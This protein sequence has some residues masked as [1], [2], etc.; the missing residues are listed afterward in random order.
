MTVEITV[1]FDDARADVAAFAEDLI[2]HFDVAAQMR[3]R[4]AGG[5]YFRT[6]RS[7]AH[8]FEWLFANNFEMSHFDNIEFRPV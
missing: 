2:C 1:R 8:F 3:G 5:L 6:E 7:P 4:V